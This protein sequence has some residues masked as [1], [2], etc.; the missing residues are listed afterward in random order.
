MAGCAAFEDV[1]KRKALAILSVK[2]QRLGETLLL[3]HGEAVVTEA[4]EQIDVTLDLAEISL[5]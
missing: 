2:R 5:T 3:D 4:F 1:I